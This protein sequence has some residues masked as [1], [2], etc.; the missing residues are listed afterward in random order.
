MA[1]SYVTVVIAGPLFMVVMLSIMLIV[2][3]SNQSAELFLFFLIFIMLP[4]AHTGFSWVI[5]NLTPEA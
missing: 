4:L 5:K 3:R 1:E 2:G